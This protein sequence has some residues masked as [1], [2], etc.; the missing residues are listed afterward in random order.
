MLKHQRPLLF[1]E[2]SLYDPNI[3]AR[4]EPGMAS[5]PLVPLISRGR[6]IG[7]LS[8]MGKQGAAEAIYGIDHEGCYCFAKMACLHMLGF[9]H[10]S[11]Q[12][13]LFGKP[14]E[15]ADWAASPA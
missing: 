8:A 1:G 14:V 6:I 4:W 2:G 13:S 5:S 11:D 15:I 12:G 7:G 3:E 9:T 10:E